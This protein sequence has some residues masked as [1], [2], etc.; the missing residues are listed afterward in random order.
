[1][2]KVLALAS[3][4]AVV[5]FSKSSCCLCYAVKILFQEIGV[6]PLVYDIDGDPDGREMEKAIVRLGC[7]APLPAVFING[8]LVGSTNEIMS[9]HLSGTLSQM[10]KSNQALS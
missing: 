3:D 10:L 6:D 2:N 1:M 8:K 5:I 4:K 7:N 9:L